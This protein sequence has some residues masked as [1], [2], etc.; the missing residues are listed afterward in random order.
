[1]AEFAQLALKEVERDTGDLDKLRI[2]RDVR[3][4]TQEP[5]KSSRMAAY[6]TLRGFH[7]K[8]CPICKPEV[9]CATRRAQV[10]LRDLLV[11]TIGMGRG[12]WDYASFDLALQNALGQG[13]NTGELDL[14]LHSQ[15]TL[16]FNKVIQ[17][18]QNK[19][20]FKKHARSNSMYGPGITEDE[21]DTLF[22]AYSCFARENAGH[23]SKNKAHGKHRRRK[24]SPKK[25]TAATAAAAES[26]A[27]DEVECDEG[28]DE[29]GP[30]YTHVSRG[31]MYVVT[32]GK[33]FA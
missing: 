28:Q 22:V 25:S 24:T 2:L 5:D 14:K 4:L 15:L 6:N 33:T 10:I 3:S 20:E 26:A 9:Y 8:N 30:V 1:M 19:K 18:G 13:R 29:K 32:Q 27:E 21:V 31:V 11:L 12:K 23:V 7:D 17:L 16:A